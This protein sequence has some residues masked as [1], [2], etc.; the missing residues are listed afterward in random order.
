MVT[1][2]AVSDTIAVALERHVEPRERVVAAR[3]PPRRSHPRANG[4]GR[5]SR[6]APLSVTTAS[7]EEI[8]R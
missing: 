2:L 5:R 4:D 8:Q 6:R 7:D 3:R 1:V